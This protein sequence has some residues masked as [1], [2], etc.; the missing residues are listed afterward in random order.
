[1][2]HVNK[3]KSKSTLRVP[4]WWEPCCQAQHG[5]GIAA[6]LKVRP[7]ELKKA[8][9]AAKVSDLPGAARPADMASCVAPCAVPEPGKFACGTHR[10]MAA[11]G[12]ALGLPLTPPDQALWLST[13]KRWAI[14]GADGKVLRYV[15]LPAGE[16]PSKDTVR[17]DRLRGM[18]K[19][20]LAPVLG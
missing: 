19:A 1:M 12:L 3:S 8:I 4:G 5:Q 11:I 2:Q 14:L 17:A 7:K 13:P 9:T 16:T 18:A 6:A 20:E 15:W 10:L